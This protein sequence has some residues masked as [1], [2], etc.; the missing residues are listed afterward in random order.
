[1]I[2]NIPAFARFLEAISFSHISVLN[3]SE[4]ARE[5]LVER[6]TVEG[7]LRVLE[8]LLLCFNIDVFNKRSKRKLLSHPKFYFFDI[9]FFRHLRPKGPLDS[10]Y[11]IDGQSL[12][13]LVAQSLRAWMSYRGKSNNLYYWRTQKGIEVDFILYGEDGLFAI[14]VKNS[15]KIHRSHLKSLEIFNRDYPEAKCILLYRGKE[16]MKKNNILCI[17]V[18]EFLLKLIPEYPLEF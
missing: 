6:K 17:P 16:R 2:R 1:M 10:P 12:E 14:E 7:Y 15:L 13:G 18:E 9:G 5:C 11:E 3:I 8:D 4:V